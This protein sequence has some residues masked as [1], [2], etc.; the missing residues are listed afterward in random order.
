M[1]EIEVGKHNMAHVPCR[2]SQPLKLSDRR[3]L[4]IELDTIEMNKERAE[5]RVRRLDIA[6][7]EASIDQNKSLV[8]LDK[9]AVADEA[10]RQ[11]TTE[12]IEEC[13][14]DRAHAATIEMMN[15]HKCSALNSY[16]TAPRW[17]AVACFFFATRQ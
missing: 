4:A 10:S 16:M 12:A 13:P 9:Q 11:T 17:I 5:P 15:V 1:I 3:V 7:T 2:K 6:Q 8:R 14:T